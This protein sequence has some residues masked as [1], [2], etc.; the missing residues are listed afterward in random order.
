MVYADE[1]G[2]FVE[3]FQERRYRDAAGVSHTFV[4]DNLSRSSRGVLRGLHLQTKNPQ[5]KL[6]RAARGAVFDVAA[7]VNP[8]SLSFGRWFGTLLSDENQRQVWIPPGY[9]H[10]YVVVSEVA[11]FEYKCTAYYDP[12]AEAGVVWNDPDLNIEWPIERPIVSK[13]DLALP[14]LAMLSLT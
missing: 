5:G 2:Y 9:A 11:D 13:R 14:T 8:K 10:G 4:Q 7:D 3:T 12:T 1:R 6:V